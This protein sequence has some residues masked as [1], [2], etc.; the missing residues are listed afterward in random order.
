M[1]LS[2]S[3]FASDLLTER[4]VY[5]VLSDNFT[6]ATMYNSESEDNL[7][8]W[9]GS[10]LGEW[11]AVAAVRVSS[12]PAFAL[13]GKI[14]WE[15]VFDRWDNTT[16]G[17]WAAVAFPFVDSDSMWP[18]KN[19]FHNV[20]IE[21]TD[22]SHFKYLDFWVKPKTG[23]ITKVLVGINDGADRRV[24]FGSLGV[25]N[26]QVWQHVVIDMTTLSSRLAR[27]RK[28]FVLG[29]DSQLDQNT[30]FFVDNVVLRTD[31]PSASFSATLKNVEAM[32]NIP[33]NPD[34][35]IIWKQT[36]FRNLDPWQTA[37]QYIEL[38]MDM[39]IPS[40]KV[41]LYSDNGG[42]GRGG[43]WAQGTTREYVVPMCWRAYNGELGNQ[44]G[45]DTFFIKEN[46]DG[47]LY[48][49][50]LNSGADS[51]W[52]YPWLR[53]KDHSDPDFNDDEAYVT[54]W[55]SSKG[56]RET[57]DPYEWHDGNASGFT[58]GFKEFNTVVKK[59][60]IYFGGNFGDAAGGITYTGNIVVEL[61]YE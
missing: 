34:G 60:K 4:N 53:M 32:Q 10:S 28:P 24:T 7:G 5:G 52:Y 46:A 20:E 54:V 8:Y 55:D 9:V 16:Q 2:V 57:S 49:G 56:Y 1:F 39:C 59:P 38:D 43:M 42:A 19:G 40:W 23:D 17:Y 37:C 13:E 27:V 30:A 61:S 44:P 31:S 47:K 25:T 48:D 26:E 15:M 18:D 35:N 33:S 14:Y 22:I 45:K 21:A 29:A 41:K 3:V 12:T 6:G 51:G 58:D 11:N 36:A 50:M